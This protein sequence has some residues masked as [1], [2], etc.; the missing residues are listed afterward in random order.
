MKLIQI[1]GILLLTTLI[2]CSFINRNKLNESDLRYIEEIGL[3]DNNEKVLIFSS[4]YTK[5]KSGNFITN[6][7]VAAYWI[8]E[9]ESESYKNYAFFSDILK[10]DPV[11]NTD[12]WTHTSYL[13]IT[14][15]DSTNFK[16]YIDGDKK[17]YNLFVHTA[18]EAWAKNKN[19]E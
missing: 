12:A 18:L 10:I 17:K 2:G 5:K 4:S 3:L 16:V 19:K 1:S 14:K 9:D 13:I 7:R 8:D 6:K 15:K 11:D